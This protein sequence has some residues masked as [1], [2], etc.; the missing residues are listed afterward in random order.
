M[1]YV[2]GQAVGSCMHYD[3]RNNLRVEDYS[4]SKDLI[5]YDIQQAKRF[6]MNLLTRLVLLIQQISCLAGEEASDSTSRDI[7][8][9]D[10][11]EQGGKTVVVLL[12]HGAKSRYQILHR[13][14]MNGSEPIV[15]NQKCPWNVAD[16]VL[17]SQ[18]LQRWSAMCS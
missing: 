12:G 9:G 2:E 18:G 11:I 4:K 8:T 15:D 6:N 16:V 13:E 14:F 3:L 7:Q 17:T 5:R 10:C 1:H